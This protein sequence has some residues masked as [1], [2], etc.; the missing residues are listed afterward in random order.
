MND[1]MEQDRHDE[2]GD[3]FDSTPR[4]ER[5][6]V[7]AGIA[8]RLSSR[9]MRLTGR[10]SSDELVT[11]L[12]ALEAFERATQAKGADLMMDEGPA[13]ASLQPDDAQFVLP[14]RATD[15]TVHQYVGRVREATRAVERH[16]PL[17]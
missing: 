9:G 16:P 15:E 14:R 17:G 5:E 7:G 4:G 11:L 1:A 2:R 10:E 8:A 12:E 3:T 13:A 6:R